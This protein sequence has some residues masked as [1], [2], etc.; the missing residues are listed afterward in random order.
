MPITKAKAQCISGIKQAK[1][2]ITAAVTDAIRILYTSKNVKLDRG[3]QPA[4]RT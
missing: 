3:I 2:K 1:P 4:K